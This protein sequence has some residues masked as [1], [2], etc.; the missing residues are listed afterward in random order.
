MARAADLVSPL[1]WALILTVCVVDYATG[2]YVTVSIFYLAPI[3]VIAWRSGA[4]T[5]AVA[6]L[7][8]TAGSLV[9]D[10]TSAS[11]E[12]Y[13][14]DPGELTAWWN[15]LMRPAAGALVVAL[16]VRQRRVLRREERLARTDE[17]TGAANRRQ[18]LDALRSEMYR[19]ERYCRPLT[20][21]LV[22]VDRFK[23]IND[24][25]GHAAGDEVLRNVATHLSQRRR[26]VDLVARLGGDEFAL[27]LPETDAR[28]AREVLGR[29]AVPLEI[30]P[31]HE[32][33]D[34]VEVRLSTGTATVCGPDASRSV[35]DVL[36]EADRS[37]YG[38]KGSAEPQVTE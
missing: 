6:V 10:L 37:L 32:R 22:D 31:G 12:L 20:V 25:Y 38:A 4:P 1:A 16:V 13:P 33:E 3:A 34:A 21:V 2:P 36:A 19:S 27:L 14:G 28:S 18:F 8:V 29:L 23:R 7:L 9:G 17:L 5:G 15:A 24:Q 26:E 11:Q 35:E 30:Q